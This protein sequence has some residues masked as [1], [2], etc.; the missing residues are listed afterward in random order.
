MS[1]TPTHE[2]ALWALPGAHVRVYVQAPPWSWTQ[3]CSAIQ[4]LGA[5]GQF[6]T[7]NIGQKNAKTVTEAMIELGCDS[8][9][10]QY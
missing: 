4:G 3:C 5:G 6:I 8:R 9:N 2:H 1:S 7:G 10:R